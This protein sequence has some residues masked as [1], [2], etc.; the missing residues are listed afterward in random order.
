MDSLHEPVPEQHANQESSPGKIGSLISSFG[1]NGKAH[2]N[3]FM[4]SE[5]LNWVDYI[6]L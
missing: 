4:V 1:E 6:L 3:L 5:A 2:N